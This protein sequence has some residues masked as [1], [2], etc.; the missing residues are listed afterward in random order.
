MDDPKETALSRHNRTD[1]HR[2]T[3]SVTADRPAQVLTSH[4]PEQ[5]RESGYK[6][7]P[8]PRSY[9]QVTVAGTGKLS[10]QWSVTGSINHIPGHAWIRSSGQDKI[11]SIFY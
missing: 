3:E 2:V 4:T 8:E 7:T 6:V 9:L 11:V 1:A 5:R 10:L